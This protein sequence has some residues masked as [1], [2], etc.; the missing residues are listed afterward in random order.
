MSSRPAGGSSKRGRDPEND[1]DDLDL[2]LRS[3][4]LAD[5]E[6]VHR[7][8]M[9]TR[10]FDQPLAPR[11]PKSNVPIEDIDM[12]QWVNVNTRMSMCVVKLQIDRDEKL[13]MLI[14]AGARRTK[15]IGVDDDAHHQSYMRLR[16][17]LSSIIVSNVNDEQ[18]RF[19]LDVFKQWQAGESRIKITFMY[20]AK[21]D[22][23]S[24]SCETLWSPA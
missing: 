20:H 5:D 13:R 7:A 10:P 21:A 14:I 2:D 19:H 4:C 11:A 18:S 8:R 6:N 23:V 1:D 15:Y 12:H 9:P 3:M 22:G 24:H 16:D 17:I